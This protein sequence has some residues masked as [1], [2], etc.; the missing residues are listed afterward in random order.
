MKSYRRV[1]PVGLAAMAGA[2]IFVSS[3][4]ASAQQ[5][6]VPAVVTLAEAIRMA[7]AHDPAAVAAEAAVATAEA[8][9][10]QA[11][12]A[13]LPTLT[14][15]SAYGNSS[16]Q[17]FDQSTGRLVSESYTAQAAGSYELFSGGRRLLQHRAA[18]AEVAAADAQYRAQRFQTILRTTAAFYDAAA[19]ADLV[20][21]AAQRFERARQQLE[22]AETR[23]EVGTATA[24]D[25]LRA[26][27]EVGNAELAV[28]E[29]EAAL[30]TAEL[31]LG[32][33]VGVAGAAQPAAASLPERAPALPPTD[34]LVARAVRASPAVV[35]AEATL[36]S[37]RAE[38]LASYTP[39][40][41]SVRLS[42]GYDWFAFRFPPDQQ[43]W[44][45][46][47]FATLPLFNGFQREAALQR[48]AA[49]ERL[50]RARALDAA[51]AA[52]V[53]V[54]SALQDIT[55]AERRVAISDR[56]VN[57]AREDLRVQE[58]RYQLGA[59]TILDLQASQLTLAEVEVAAVRARQALG[60]AVARLEAVLGEAVGGG[61]G[62]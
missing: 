7:L 38:R 43:S 30:R 9:L 51:I 4:G 41:P 2:A 27:L 28:I 18:S 52:R 19:A 26:E 44:S 39:Y 3:P 54:E 20:R 40:L 50:A 17:R 57:L 42:G 56:A 23:L 37:R 25:V 55:A 5:S 15:S 48:A 13:W 58:E 31:E 53:A 12:G 36:R 33:Q 22:F 47:V 46:R 34:Q 24:S 59:S 14:L 45:V 32:R 60:T 10:L 16:N 35:A 29:T 49:G 61:Q 6:A 1:R 8:G 21:A 62:E 11:R